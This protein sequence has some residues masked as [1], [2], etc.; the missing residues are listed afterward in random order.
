LE[1]G[2]IMAMKKTRYQGVFFRESEKR[3]HEG[4][5]DRCFYVAYRI[6]DKQKWERV[7]WLSEGITPAMAHHIRGE[8]LRAIRLG[9]DL[10]QK[11][12]APPF[13]EFALGQ[14]AE[15]CRVNNRGFEK[16]MPYIRHL[17]EY[18]GDKR[19]NKITSWDVETYKMERSQ[20]KSKRRGKPIAKA[21]VNRSLATL[22]HIFSRAVEW[23]L[24]TENPAKGVKLYKEDNGRL[25]YLTEEEITR[26]LSI[27]EGDLRDI[28]SLA[29]Y[30]SMRR[31]EILSLRWEDVNLDLQFIHVVN[32]KSRESRDIPMAREVF[33]MLLNRKRRMEEGQEYVFISP[34]TGKPYV[35]LKT[36]FVKALRKA[37]IHDATFHTLRHTFCSH[38]VMKGVDL[39]T[40]GQLAGHKTIAMTKRYSHL[41]PA[42]KQRAIEKLEGLGKGENKVVEFRLEEGGPKV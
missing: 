17:A 32:T 33:E 27:C 1:E 13:K 34:K 28:V 19:L 31:G 21:T 5:P 42:H 38:L 15:W 9:K 7:G 26:L 25:R 37:N 12:K 14:Y 22:K 29:I 10:P 39:Y 16:K 20:Q 23:G 6:E 30:T 8:R 24:I 11:K 2:E 3:K 4:K 18:F 36:S 35:D 41:S 40:V